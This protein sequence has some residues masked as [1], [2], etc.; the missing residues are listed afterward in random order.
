VKNSANFFQE[1]TRNDFPSRGGRG[2]EKRKAFSM[3][4]GDGGEEE[5]REKASETQVNINKKLQI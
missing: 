4:F 1:S 2:K 5:E 3:V